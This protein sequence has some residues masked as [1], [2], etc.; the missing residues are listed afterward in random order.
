MSNKFWKQKIKVEN[1]LFAAP[2]NLW[3]AAKSYFEFCDNN[4][5]IDSKPFHHQGTIVYAEIEKRMPYHLKGLFVFIRISEKE[6][7]ELPDSFNKV[8]EL[9]ENVIF[10][11]KITGAQQ[12]FFDAGV[13]TRDLGLSE[14]RENDNKLDFSDKINLN[15]NFHDF[16]E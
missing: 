9:I 16:S 1:S 5:D 11:Q 12:G 14:K 15:V 2:E 4:P 6:Y 8:K 7:N 10:T 3:A 13:V